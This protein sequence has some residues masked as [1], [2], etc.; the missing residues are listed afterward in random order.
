MA[1]SNAT[2]RLCNSD[3]LHDMPCPRPLRLHGGI[4]GLSALCEASCGQSRS[5]YCTYLLSSNDTRSVHSFIPSLC[6]ADSA[7]VVRNGE[8]CFSGMIR[9]SGW[10]DQVPHYDI[11]A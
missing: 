6:L 2:G 1:R 9:P 5:T 7:S 11:F 4:I 8:S 10:L 3:S